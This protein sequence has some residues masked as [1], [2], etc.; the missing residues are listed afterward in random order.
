MTIPEE[1]RTSAIGLANYAEQ[2]LRAADAAFL[3]EYERI[4]KEP[5]FLVPA[6]HLALHSIE[7]SLKAFLFSKGITLKDLRRKFGHDVLAIHGEARDRGLMSVFPEGPDDR[8]TLT[9]LIGANEEQALRYQR[10][11]A[12]EC[13]DWKTTRSLAYRLCRAAAAD[14]GW[15]LKIEP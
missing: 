5:V 4:G 7:L 6:W 1:E 15:R 11:G 8:K 9:L 3:K 13:A 2:Y 12:F 10:A 14:A